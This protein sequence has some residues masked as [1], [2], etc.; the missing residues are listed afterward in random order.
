MASQGQI[1]KILQNNVQ[2]FANDRPS[3]FALFSN[4]GHFTNHFTLQDQLLTIRD[5][6][7]HTCLQIFLKLMHYFTMFAIFFKIAILTLGLS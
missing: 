7:I 6:K 2:N 5:K 1:C 4:M 3:S